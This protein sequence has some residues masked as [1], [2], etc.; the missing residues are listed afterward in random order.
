SSEHPSSRASSSLL[1]SPFSQLFSLWPCVPPVL[2]RALRKP[3]EPIPHEFEASPI[4]VIHAISPFLIVI[5]QS[6][7]FEYPNVPSRGRPSML[8][9]VGDLAGG[10]RSTLE[11]QREQDPSADRM[12]E[13]CKNRLV[14]VHP[15][16]WLL[17][18]CFAFCHHDI[19]SRTAKYCQ[20]IF[21]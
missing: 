4:N 15:G 20:T 8:K 9:H 21:S 1:K 7:R 12:G 19:F 10:H 3:R 14:R 11:V 5:E 18:G 6:G 17:H 2:V 16:L 13:R